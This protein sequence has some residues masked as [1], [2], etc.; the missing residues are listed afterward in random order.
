[1]FV[2]LSS[3]DNAD[4]LLGWTL[5]VIF[6]FKVVLFTLSVDKK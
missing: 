5:S 3:T 6:E 1:M 2:R 4:M